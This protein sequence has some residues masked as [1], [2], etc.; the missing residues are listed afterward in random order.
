[1]EI[2][3]TSR[4]LGEGERTASAGV[5]KNGIVLLKTDRYAGLPLINACLY[6]RP[7]QGKQAYSFATY[8][9]PVNR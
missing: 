7:T 2:Q 1:M 9:P 8:T 6:G 4:P 5:K 3:Q